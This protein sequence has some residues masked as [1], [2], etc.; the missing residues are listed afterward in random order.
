MLTQI[1]TGTF[2]YTRCLSILGRVPLRYQNGC[3]FCGSEDT[4]EDVWHFIIE[5]PAFEKERIETMPGNYRIVSVTR[6]GH[7]AREINILTLGILLGG[8]EELATRRLSALVAE[9]IRF[10]AKT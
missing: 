5:C 3:A 9:T 1:R 10:L 6:D 4:S 2:P 8:E 7:R